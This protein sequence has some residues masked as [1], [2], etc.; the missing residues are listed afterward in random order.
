M[1][2]KKKKTVVVNAGSVIA[3]AFDGDGKTIEVIGD[4]S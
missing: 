4:N 1:T 2:L 3:I